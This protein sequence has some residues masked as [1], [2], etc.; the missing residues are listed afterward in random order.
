ML[1]FKKN[2]QITCN[3]IEEITVAPGACCCCSCCCCVSVGVGGDASSSVSLNP[4]SS[5]K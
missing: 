3:N 1:K 4:N 2:V 5:G